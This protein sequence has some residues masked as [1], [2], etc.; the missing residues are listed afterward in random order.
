MKVTPKIL[1]GT[2]VGLGL[3]PAA[4]VGL[5]FGADGNTPVVPHNVSQIG[6]PSS[7]PVQ[8]VTKLHTGAASPVNKPKVVIKTS[9]PAKRLAVAANDPTTE[10]TPSPTD[11]VDDPRP[12]KTQDPKSGPGND[13]PPTG[14]PG[15]RSD[16]PTNNGSVGSS[17][18][19]DPDNTKN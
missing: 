10:P 1:F 6:T 15:G 19:P 16:P 17:S 7:A 9:A 2:I 8:V 18:S 12:V 4:A 3:A 14:N 11:S 5:S 13:V